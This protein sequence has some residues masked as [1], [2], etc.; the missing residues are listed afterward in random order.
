LLVIRLVTYVLVG[1]QDG[2][3]SQSVCTSFAIDG[4]I[5][6]L[7]NGFTSEILSW[8]TYSH[9]TH[10]TTPPKWL[11]LLVLRIFHFTVGNHDY[12][13]FTTMQLVLLLLLIV[14]V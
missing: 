4:Q 13:G 7:L 1:H 11:T 10:T 5:L 2:C 6:I 3:G 14:F 12:A 9:G 8:I